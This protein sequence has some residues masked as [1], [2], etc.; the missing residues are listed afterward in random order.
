[1]AAARAL[2][3]ALASRGARVIVAPD[4]DADGLAAGALAIRALERLGAVP[5]ALLLRKGEHVH[6]PAMR[7]RL[8]AAPADALLVLDMGSRRGPILE[9]R[10]TIVIDHH[11]ARETPDVD[12][13]VS[14]A[15]CEPVAPTGLL[16]YELFRALVDLDD[17]AWYAVV[18]TIGDLGEQHPF[19]A[20]LGAIAARYRKTHLKE[21][22]ALLNGARRHGS[23]RPELAL[24]ALLAAREPADIARGLV[25]GAAELAA[26]RDEV[27]AEVRRVM[28]T[29]PVFG[30]G[31]AMI[32]F[33]SSAQIHPLIATRWA[34]RLAPSIVFA[35]NDG[36]LPGRTNFAVRSAADVDLLAFLRALPMGTVVGEYANGHPRATGGSL[37][38]DELARMLDALGL[39]AA[40]ARSSARA[41]ST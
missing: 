16:T 22:V 4:R 37:P 27:N 19:A 26:M 38:P 11:D 29:A 3:R 14:A 7:E 8:A 10:P 41:A 31:V 15:G 5:T 20:Q 13:F 39:D 21:T 36:Y 17:V 2:I 25:P 6:S 24:T 33:A 1:M 30:R 18:A 40:S 28:H 35:V 12:V 23:H 32:R 34:K 9:G